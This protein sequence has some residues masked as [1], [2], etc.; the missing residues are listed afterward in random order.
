[1]AEISLKRAESAA[2]VEFTVQ[3]AQSNNSRIMAAAELAGQFSAAV[4]A[5]VA[6]ARLYGM[7][8]QTTVTEHTPDQP[9]GAEAE[10]LEQAARQYKIKLAGTG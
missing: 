1:M 4:S 9:I 5:N 10:A 7:D 3:T 2:K 6:N 8:K